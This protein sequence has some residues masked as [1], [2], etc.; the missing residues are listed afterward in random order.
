M[1]LKT[2]GASIVIVCAAVVLSNYVR[3]NPC[4]V[5]GFNRRRSRSVAELNR[6]ARDGGR[7]F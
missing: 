7:L 5:E 1:L 3:E 2:A 4:P 6:S